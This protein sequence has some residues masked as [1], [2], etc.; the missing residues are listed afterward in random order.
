[1]PALATTTSTGPSAASI[2]VNAASIDAAV[3]DV[4]AHGEAAGR[5]LARAGGDGDP[6]ALGEEF[7][8]DGE[9]DAPVA[10]GDE[11]CASASSWRGPI[12]ATPAECAGTGFIQLRAS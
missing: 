6:V 12:V 8:G 11:Y 10:S 5:A 9:A 7:L 3:G 2:S 4:G 1:M